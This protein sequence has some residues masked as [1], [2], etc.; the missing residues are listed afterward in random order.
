MFLIKALLFRGRDF[1]NAGKA[2][3]LDAGVRRDGQRHH[4]NR[5][6]FKQWADARRPEGKTP[7]AWTAVLSNPGGLAS[8]IVNVLSQFGLQRSCCFCA[9]EDYCEGFAADHFQRAVTESC[10]S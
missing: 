8:G 1:G 7:R 2:A 5:K 10:T 3:R 4:L 9:G 6:N